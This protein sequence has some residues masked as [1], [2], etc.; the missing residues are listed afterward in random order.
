M[1]CSKVR[2]LLSSYA[3]GE[4][5]SRARDAV[6]LH[7]AGCAECRNELAELQ[8][9]SNLLQAEPAPE[10]SPFLAGRVLAAV[11]RAPAVKRPSGLV[12]AVLTGAVAAVLVAVGLWL[13]TTLGKGV[14][15]QPSGLESL[16]TVNAEPTL[17][18]YYSSLLGGE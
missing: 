3:D 17:G 15:S 13:G 7:L 4:L 16:L 5:D 12:A 11:K 10:P 18:S 1:N 9:D 2:R 6:E 8:A 14:I